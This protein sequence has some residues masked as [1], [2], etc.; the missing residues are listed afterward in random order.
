[1]SEVC[2]NVPGEHLM[3]DTSS[4]K[5]KSYGS[6]KFGYWYSSMTAWIRLGVSS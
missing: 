3:I 5:K 2:S 6:K 4:I 1:M